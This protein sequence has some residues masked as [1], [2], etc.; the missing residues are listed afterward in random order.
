MHTIAVLV[1]GGR[2]ALSG[3]H[4]HLLDDH[5][6][7]LVPALA[8]LVDAG[9]PLSTGVSPGAAAASAAAAALRSAADGDEPAEYRPFSPWVSLGGVPSNSSSLAAY[10]AVAPAV[11]RQAIDTLASI[12]A[13]GVDLT[14]F[15]SRIVQPLARAI[16]DADAASG[17][18]DLKCAALDC[19]CLLLLQL[20]EDFVVWIPTVRKACL[21]ATAAAV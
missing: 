7:V 1:C 3:G 10:G 8:R 12:A 20:R 5:F 13:A 6:Q 16:A 14:P 19:L 11:R 4:R 9:L 21:A 17:P 15:A 18:S 2:R